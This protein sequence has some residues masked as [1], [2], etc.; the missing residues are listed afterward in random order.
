MYFSTTWSYLSGFAAVVYIAAASS[1]VVFG[2]DLRLAVTPGTRQ[3]GGPWWS[4]IRPQLVAM[5]ALV[6]AAAIGLVRMFTGLGAPA[7]TLVNVAWV[8]FDLLILS[9]IIRA[10][11]YQGNPSMKVANDGL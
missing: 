1:T 11:R 8:I 10:A 7:G 6:L 9:L 5:A 4:L 2:R 3:D